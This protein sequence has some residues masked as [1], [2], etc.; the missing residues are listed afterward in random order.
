MKGYQ[1]RARSI[2]GVL[3]DVKL[4]DQK[5]PRSI[6]LW[7]AVRPLYRVVIGYDAAQAIIARSYPV[8]MAGGLPP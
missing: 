4:G 2:S 6:L 5:A 3:L 1:Y 8:D 7:E